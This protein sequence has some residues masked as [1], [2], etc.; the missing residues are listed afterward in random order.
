M[1]SSLSI[2]CDSSQLTQELALG[3]DLDKAVLRRTLIANRR[4]IAAPL[5][6]TWDAAL[7]MRL[8][9]WWTAQPVTSL[10]VY[11]PM[12]DEPDLRTAFAELAARGVQLALP[13][14][15]AP[16]AP[17]AFAA[18]APGDALVKDA[19]GV[20]IPA[21]LDFVPCPQALLIPCVGFNAAR[22]RLGYG[23]GYYDRTLALAPR[24]LT[25]GVAYSCLAASFDAA[26]HD[27]ALDAI[28]TESEESGDSA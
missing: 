10:G 20:S 21:S 17:L 7:C 24:P 2:A 5:R 9:A 13:V 22:F 16:A 19:L 14:V 8:L 26:P 4:A 28:L 1:T 27:I 25:V 23:G 15:T 18:W 11:W 3:I 6:S 12:Q